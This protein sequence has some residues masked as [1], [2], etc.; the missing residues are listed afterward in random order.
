[1][2]EITTLFPKVPDYHK[3]N[4]PLVPNGLGVI[5]VLIATVYLFLVYFSGIIEVTNGVSAPLTLAVC[6]LFGGFMGLLDDW[7]DLRWRYK[8]FLPLIAAI[9]LISLAYK[10]HLRTSILLPIFGMIDFGV[11]YYFLLVPLLVTIV[12]N[13]VNQLGGL[14]G[15]ETICPAIIITGLMV[16]SK[17]YVI[18]LLGPL[19]AWLVLAVLNFEG[20]IF[21]G[22]TGSFAI[23]MTLAGFAIISDFKLGLVISVLPY[24]LN[25][26][27][28]LLTYFF[29]RKKASL[30]FDGARLV[31]D[32]RR[33]LVT[34]ITYRR[35]LTERQTV[36]VI[37]LLFAFSTFVGL[38]IEWVS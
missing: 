33:S 35:P 27:M 13:S 36:L 20:K 15:L 26:S 19:I 5:Y 2:K 28:I 34:L 22:N 3:P 24:V 38:L 4:K 21:V 31:S 29:S 14:N 25:S 32:H 17:S 6:V 10:F 37:S 7:L 12:T 30:S 18:L 8:A 9:P 11:Y 16:F 23:G 1:L